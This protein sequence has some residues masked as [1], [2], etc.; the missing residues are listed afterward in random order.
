M[1]ALVGAFALRLGGWSRLIHSPFPI[2]LTKTVYTTNYV[3]VEIPHYVYVW[4]PGIVREEPVQ[5]TNYEPFAFSTNNPLYGSNFLTTNFVPDTI[6]VTN[7]YVT[8]LV[9]FMTNR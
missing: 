7:F 3:T 6:Y 5:M 4:L 9:S 2:E 1:C 8:N